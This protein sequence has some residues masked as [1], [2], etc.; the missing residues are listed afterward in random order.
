VYGYEILGELGR[1]SMGVVYKARQVGLDR[2]VALKM[3]RTGA[4]AGPEELQRFIA[5]ARV[6]AA[7]QHPNIIQIYDINLSQEAPYFSMELVEGGTLAERFGGRPQPF[8][9]AA[10]LVLTLARAV[11]V[12]HDNGIVHRDLKPANILLAAPEGG[13]SHVRRVA[14]EMDLHPQDFY[15][16]TP[17]IT[18]FGLAKQ[19]QGDGGQTESG[20]VLGT[21]SYM[22]P[23]Q[24]EGRSREVGPAADVYAL[25]AIL[26][27]AL[28][29]R[30]PFT[31]ESPME[32]VLLLFQTEPVSPSRLQPR[33]P[34]DLETICLKC[35]HKDPQRRYASAEDL[36]ADLQH[37]LAGEPI[38]ARP[39]SLYEQAWKWVKRRPALATLGACAA[40]AVLGLL[41][42]T[43]WHQVDLRTRL[44]QALDDERAARAAQE[45]A[46]ERERQSQQ[47]DKVK[48]LLHAG[49]A[50]LA[51]QDW[52]HAQLQLTRA[53][54]Q[55]AG[56]A[57]CADL[58]EQVELLLRQTGQRRLDQERLQKFQ[59]LRNEAL[60]HATL[61]T[62]TDLA[63][64]LADT[65]SAALE[66]L[67]LFGATPDSTG[68][69]AVQ[70]P[71]YEAATRAEIVAGC[72]EL[73]VVLAEAVAQPLPG[74][75]AAGQR[76]GAEEALRI[77]DRAA[78]L[79][80][81]TQAYHR[82]RAHYLAQAGRE[83]AA[84]GER[85]RASALRP[86]TALDHFLLGQEQYRQAQTAQA[87]R[88]FEDV[89][90]D[91]PDDFWAGY[92]LALCSL[93]AQRPDQAA[94]RLTACLAR[95]PDF[96]WLHLLRASAW[97]E[98]GQFDRA[99]ADFEAAL[100]APLPDGARYG[101]LVNRGVLR[102]RQG[103]LDR[104]VA[105]LQAAVAL[106]PQQYQ[107]YVNL[108][109]AHL[110][111]QCPEEA[112]RQLDLAIQREPGL[113]SL[114]RTRARIEHLLH[115]DAA[116]L[117]DLDRAIRLEPAAATASLAEDHLER[118]RLL[119]TGK[120]FA[121]ALEACDAALLLRPRDARACRLRAEALLEL[122]HL[123]EALQ[124]LDD[125]IRY[126]PPDAGT[127]RARAALRTRLGQ[128]PG[129]QADYTRA[130]EIHA[131]AATWAARGWCC[132][133]A[134]APKLA[135]PDFEQ[136]IR[137]APEEGDAYAGR[138][139][140]RALLGQYRPA[141]ADAEEALRLGPRAPRLCYNTARIF[142]QAAARLE[143]D[144]PRDH[145]MAALLK[146]SWQERGV[147]QL[148][149]ALSMQ[150]AAE[151]A[152]FWQNVI[153]ADKALNPLRPL[154][155]FRQ[156]ASRYAGQ[157]ARAPGV[158]PWPAGP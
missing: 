138:G 144:P 149:V 153:D 47:R 106:R 131:D 21:P 157:R 134:D 58:R 45:A 91:Q 98:L 46:G 107:G 13:S 48:D 96:P 64:A 143:G 74:Q 116:A 44:G 16:G 63:S 18:D 94:A 51:A 39:A 125:C 9:Q 145:W 10:Q 33:V 41:A 11:H 105:D 55:A 65:R 128:Y 113:A 148:A 3:I 89:L 88:A 124:A 111:S 71:F 67:T 60:F 99:E 42:L 137:L 57:E 81:T 4:H 32:T 93:K 158:P 129:A 120:D 24:A 103:K 142:A 123:P 100:K 70:S 59:R 132:L 27:E 122:K 97:G 53:R 20:M 8:R 155:G 61:F 14:R 52:D 36:A 126:G 135:L 79:G 151:A 30:P 73:L 37:F 17:K 115:D 6:V 141:V 140:A 133:V 86:S 84:A 77:L 87:S 49:E 82:R 40:L 150:P 92:Y 83:E 121:A 12:A 154:Q 2:L 43:V 101:L 68:T 95:R 19:L 112:R 7:L 78:A 76:R 34:R 62:G 54:D 102:I 5:E 75:A 117:A 25:G 152:R 85:R 119:A 136:A 50:A 23:E 72:Y 26:Y 139:Y 130:L 127:F 66:A 109:Q 146:E 29:G 15:L 38:R 108:A 110:K 56:E 104:A 22:A 28:T 156:L 31:A 90:Q 147:Q 118:A 80:V 1:G 69:P 35:L 114:Y